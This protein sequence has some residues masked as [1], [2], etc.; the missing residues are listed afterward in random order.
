MSSPVSSEAVYARIRKNPKFNELVARR[1][2]F[3][4]VLSLI[5]L[6]IFYGFV[7]IVAFQP[8]AIGARVA[9]GSPL[10]VGVAGGLFIFVFF[11]VLTALYVRR[12]NG[13]FDAITQEVL[14]EAAASGG[15]R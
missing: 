11:W 13:E 8:A 1:S 15:K 12:A 14:R 3:A 9:E 10:T 4:T 6:A 5:V 2:R 7:L